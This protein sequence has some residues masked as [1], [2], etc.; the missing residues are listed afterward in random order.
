MQFRDISTSAW[1]QRTARNDGVDGNVAASTVFVG[2]DGSADAD[3]VCN[4][5]PECGLRKPI[6][7]PRVTLG[8]S[9]LR[10]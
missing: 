3:R 8:M 10:Y 5:S 6:F 9:A 1:R 4:N 7:H 2:G